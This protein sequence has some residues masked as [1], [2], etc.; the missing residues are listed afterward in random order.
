MEAKEKKGGV[1]QSVN[2]FIIVTVIDLFL[3]GGY[4]NDF[5]Q[6]NIGFGF[7]VAVVLAVLV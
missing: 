4:I 5:L 3:F 1:E 6:G 2:K 7:M